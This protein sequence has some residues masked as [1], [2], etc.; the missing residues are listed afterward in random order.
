MTIYNTTTSDHET[1][2]LMD[3]Y[4]LSQDISAIQHEARALGYLNQSIETT[5][6]LVDVSAHPADY[7]T[8][9]GLMDAV[10]HGPQS[11][12]ETRGRPGR[13]PVWPIACTFAGS[14]LVALGL[15]ASQVAQVVWSMLHPGS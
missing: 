13:M 9:T 7:V 11:H 4:V 12:A 6:P 1:W 5:V 2:P 10:S 15:G 14:I 8:M 3:S